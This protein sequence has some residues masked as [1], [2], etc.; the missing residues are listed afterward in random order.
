MVWKLSHQ[1]RYRCSIGIKESVSISMINSIK[2]KVSFL[3]LTTSLLTACYMFFASASG[4]F[5]QHKSW[6]YSVDVNKDNAIVSA[7]Q[8][9]LL[10]W[11]NRSCTDRLVGH[12]DAIKSVVFSKN[13]QYL[14]TGSIDKSVKVWSFPNKQV[15]RTLSAHRK[16]VNKVAFSNGDNYII[17][18]GYDDKLYVWDWRNERILKAFTVKH[19]GFSISR[20]DVLAYVDTACRLTLFDMKTLNIIDTPGIF[21]GSPAFHPQKNIIAVIEINQ[22]TFSLIHFT[23]GK[24]LSAF[25]IKTE[26]SARNVSAFKFTPDGNYLV[27]SVWGGDIEI[28][29]WQHKRRIRTLEA[30]HMASAEDFSFNNKG[31]LLAASADRS[32]KIWDWN[33]GKL[34]MLLGDGSF[35]AKLNGV[36]S[37]LILLTLISA[38]WVLFKGEER[39]FSSF[40]ILS[41]LTVWSF[42][43][44][45]GLYFAKSRLVRFAPFISWTATILSGLLILSLWFSAFSI[46]TIPV[47][48]FFCYIQLLSEN[49]KQSVYLPLVLNI[50]FC[51]VLCSFISSAG[52]WK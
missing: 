22:S 39:K 35:R 17:S 12:T 21:C 37:I 18:A 31:E 14:A 36:L 9:E 4:K 41:T 5:E 32:V 50:I 6:V 42:G 10:V 13:G 19:T 27:V 11:N 47:A 7:S 48:L 3:L 26:N 28:W 23:S 52:L 20:N 51:G 15:I 33:N 25:D 40:A 2:D 45:L 8:N 16:G 38:F 44:F 1:E 24:V 43:I 30:D 49:P 29:D 46:F 34:K